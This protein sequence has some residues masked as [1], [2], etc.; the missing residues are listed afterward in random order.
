M[1]YAKQV[2]QTE[3]HAYVAEVAARFEADGIT[4]FTFSPNRF[5]WHA[6]CL[7]GEGFT[8][9]GGATE[10]RLRAHDAKHISEFEDRSAVIDREGYLWAWSEGAFRMWLPKQTRFSTSSYLPSRLDVVRLHG[11]QG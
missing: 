9:S 11:E 3:V 8:E 6:R 5:G 2:S 10:A 1:S 7:C 4:R